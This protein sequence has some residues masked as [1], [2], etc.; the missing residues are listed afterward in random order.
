[1]IRIRNRS[2]EFPVAQRIY[3]RWKSGR[4]YE[5]KF[6]RELLAAVSADSVV[7]D[8]GANVG[9]YSR[10]AIAKGARHVVCIEPA[11]EA[12]ATL[13]RQL[14]SDG[15]DPT[16]YTV[17]PVA[18]SDV[19]G[20]ANFLAAGTSVTNR[21]GSPSAHGA[22]TIEVS[23]QRAEDL[24]RQQMTPGPNVVKV[25][26][27]GFELEALRG[28]GSIL[29]SP[30]LRAIFVEVHFALLHE[31]GLDSAPAEIEKLLVD[32]GFAIRWLDVSHLCAE[33]SA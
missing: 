10:Q 5:D 15:F 11:P 18:L 23:V 9:L 21:L 16:R 32:A 4:N 29:R 19:N 25:D 26:V 6:G 13:R 20:S 2:R 27:E 33:R 12:V 14:A 22:E 31:R 30:A 1:M 28:F 8:V 7:W 17:L 3:L 24:V